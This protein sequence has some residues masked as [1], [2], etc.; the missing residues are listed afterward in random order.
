M[1]RRAFERYSDDVYGNCRASE[2]RDIVS[3]HW[4]RERINDL[5]N[6]K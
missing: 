6:K 4:T 2:P 5:R 1:D 3:F